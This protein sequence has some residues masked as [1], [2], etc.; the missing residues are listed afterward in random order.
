ML[1][2]RMRRVFAAL[3]GASLAACS[4]GGGDGALEMPTIPAG[5]LRDPAE[6]ILL[7]RPSRD[8]E[9]AP[10]TDCATAFENVVAWATRWD[11]ANLFPDL[12]EILGNDND[13]DVVT[14]ACALA[15]R[16]TD[17]DLWRERARLLIE[18]AVAAPYSTAGVSA[19]GPGR[20]L[21]SYVLAASTIQLAAL[22]GP[23][24][25]AFRSWIQRLSEE[26]T[27]S[28]DGVTGTFRAY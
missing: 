11:E 23:L 5:L 6:W 18:Q 17:D 22:D 25:E 7:P 4:G 24:D 26:E 27:W 19:L 1:A 13:H 3:A 15:W 21:L 12:T 20:N 16:G 9:C 2:G 10:G 28:G 14:L 8:A